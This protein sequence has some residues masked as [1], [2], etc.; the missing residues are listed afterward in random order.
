MLVIVG[1]KI[2]YVQE[3]ELYW[4]SSI[5]ESVDVEKFSSKPLNRDGSLNKIKGDGGLVKSL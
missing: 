2:L 3:S 5:F 1:L 4:F